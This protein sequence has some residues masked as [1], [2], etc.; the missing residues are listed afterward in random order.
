MSGRR[1]AERPRGVTETTASAGSVPVAT[2][3]SVVPGH[4]TERAPV[5]VTAGL[6][7]GHSWTYSIRWERWRRKPTAPRPS[8]ATRTRLR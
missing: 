8:T 4:R 1:G 3:S 6:A 5:A 2:S 7:M